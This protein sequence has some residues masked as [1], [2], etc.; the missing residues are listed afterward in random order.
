MKPQIKARIDAVGPYVGRPVPTKRANGRVTAQNR[1]PTDCRKALT[2]RA[3]RPT[4]ENR[5]RAHPLLTALPEHVHVRS[6]NLGPTLV[7]AGLGEETEGA[8]PCGDALLPLLLD[9]L[10]LYVLRACVGPT[11]DDRTEDWARTSS[12]SPPSTH[13]LNFLT[14]ENFWTHGE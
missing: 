13:S 12:A 5:E 10:P 2:G 8:R 1:D 7:L 9:A 4:G 3:R 14:K 11:A 6:G